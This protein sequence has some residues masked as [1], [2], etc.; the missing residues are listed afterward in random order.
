MEFR[1]YQPQ[2]VILADSVNAETC[3]RWVTFEIANFPKVLL[4]ELNTH[5]MLS[6]NAASSRAMPM[7]A[8]A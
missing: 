2:A 6:R 3:D 7:R 4:Q 8:S 1:N 5:R